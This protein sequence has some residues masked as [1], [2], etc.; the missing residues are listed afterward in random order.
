MVRWEFHWGEN[1]LT[2]EGSG[3]AGPSRERR[4]RPPLPSHS[5]TSLC[6]WIVQGALESRSGSPPTTPSLHRDSS[7]RDAQ[8]PLRQPR[9]SRDGERTKASSCV[10]TPRGHPPLAGSLSRRRWGLSP[11]LPGNPCPG[12]LGAQGRPSFVRSA[13]RRD[14]DT[15]R[16]LRRGKARPTQTSTAETLLCSSD[17]P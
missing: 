6:A 8:T 17:G 11:V 3:V 13:G 2:P 1:F 4:G 12:G 5:H 9:G 16:T 10:D 14:A 15:Y 7:G